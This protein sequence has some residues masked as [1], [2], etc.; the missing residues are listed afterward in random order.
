MLSR[1]VLGLWLIGCVIGLCGNVLASFSWRK[2]G[3]SAKDLRM[4]GS[5][6]AAHPERYYRPD[7]VP[8]V[9]VVNYLAVGLFLVGVL[10]MVS[11]TFR[12]LFR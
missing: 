2:A 1:L 9:R 7:R 4:A 11:G 8:L 10:I 12:P 3:V 6:A 5:N